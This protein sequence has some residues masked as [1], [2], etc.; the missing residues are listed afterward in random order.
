[1]DGKIVGS[2]SQMTITGNGQIAMFLRQISGLENLPNRFEGILR[3]STSSEAGISVLA[4]RT[5]V[6]ERGDFLTATTP[7]FA[8]GGSSWKSPLFIPHFADSGG[9]TTRVVLFNTIGEQSPSGKL[10]FVSQ[11]GIE[12]A[13]DVLVIAYKTDG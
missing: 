9:C 2:P 4:F 3:L 6:N 11:S 7:A 13:P 5:R 12:P 10:R 1:L 8:E